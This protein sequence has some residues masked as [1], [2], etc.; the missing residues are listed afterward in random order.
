MPGIWGELKGRFLSFTMVLGVAFLLLVSLV[1]NAL[2]SVL[3]AKFSELLPGG[4]LVWQAV[5]SLFS[6]AMIA[7]LFALIFKYVPDAEIEWRDVWLGAAVTA[8]L[9][10]LGKILLGLY[11]G[12]AA[13]GSSYGAA[14]SVIALVVWVYYAAQILL[15]GAEFTQVQAR[16]SG[17]EIRPAPTRCESAELDPGNP[18][19][20]LLGLGARSAHLDRGGDRVDLGRD[21]SG[22]HMSNI[23]GKAYAMNL[24]TPL[25]ELTADLNKVVFLG[26]AAALPQGEAERVTHPQHDP[27]CALV[28]RAT[29][30]VS[31]HQR[32]AAR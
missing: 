7:G 2:L 17:R 22:N 31:A 10:T 19:T 16:R 4:E 8:A 25:T 14:G 18:A 6:L 1:L 30:G 13:I 15:L 21:R 9:F 5:S 20:T 26:A 28:D 27:L 32:R 24:V 3:G 11:L 12:K 23:A 29:L